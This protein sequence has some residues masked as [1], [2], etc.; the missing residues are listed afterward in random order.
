MLLYYFSIRCYY[1][2]YYGMS[3]VGFEPTTI[4]V[5]VYAY[6][7]PPKGC[8]FDHSGTLTD[9]IYNNTA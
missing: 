5:K 2:I 9:N 3:A 4:P 1:K 8:P 7:Q 6:A